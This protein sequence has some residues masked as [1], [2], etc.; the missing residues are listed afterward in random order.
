VNART[1]A[2]GA[3]CA[4]LAA[5]FA[6]K[7]S[8]KMPDFEVY[9]RAGA[10]A[11]AAE[12]LYRAEDGHYQLKY[13][14]AFAV[15]AIPLS[16]LPL[17]AAKGLW[18]MLSAALIAVLLARSLALLPDRR[19]PAWVLVAV[20]FVAMAKFYGH[21]LVLG[22]VNLLF[23]VVLV[24][25]AHMAAWRGSA[26]A[27]LLVA[28]AAVIKPYAV[29]FLP[30]LAGARLIAACSAALAG[31]AAILALPSLV[32]GWAASIDLHREWWRTVSD[33]TGPNLLNPDNVSLAAMYAKWFG[34]GSATA[35]L[36]AGTSAALLVLAALVFLQRRQVPAPV[37][38]EAG[39]LLTLIPLLSP[40][41]W[42][43]VFLISTPAVMYLVNYE[44]AL[45]HAM[46]ILT[47]FALGT[48]AF[49]LYDVMGRAAYAA[50]ME[51][52]AISVCFLVMV[53]ALAWL[54]VRRAA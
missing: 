17:T 53:A 24:E 45:P 37:G 5:I 46:R 2:A 54:R 43:Y 12:P 31:L 36:A 20:T 19:K 52:S 13:L 18:F 40:Q 9:W 25:A 23:A 8:E 10:R 42:D 39:L 26:G 32:Y 28:L 30:W 51:V 33:S 16:L 1:L 47:W 21:E 35:W 34:M 27:G 38:L 14:P 48:V 50:F 44:R 11:A 22:Q 41:G 4:A 49:S 15:L 7:A 6:F 29:I 3:I